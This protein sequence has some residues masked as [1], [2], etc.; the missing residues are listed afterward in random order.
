MNWVW[1]LKLAY[2]P[3]RAIR[4]PLDVG[5]TTLFFCHGYPTPMPINT[6]Q[7]LQGLEVAAYQASRDQTPTICDNEERKL[8][9]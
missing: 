9:R 7:K 4:R 5:F 2:G 8:E 3:D 6:E 1:F